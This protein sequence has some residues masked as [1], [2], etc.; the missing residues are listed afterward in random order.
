VGVL[1]PTPAVLA[2]GFEGQPFRRPNDIVVDRNG[3]VYFTDDGNPPEGQPRKPG[4]FY[5]T[6]AGRLVKLD[7]DIEFPNGVMLSPDEKVLY[8]ANSGKGEFIVAFDVGPD[9]L[10]S[11][12]R[13]FARLVARSGADGLAVDAAGRLYVASGGVQVFS[14]Q[15]QHLGT[16]PI[17]RSTQNVAFAGPDKKTLYVVGSGAVYK[18]A[19]LAEGFKGRAK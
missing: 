17:P 10:V 8:V 12:R 9:G 3:G 5:I 18:I 13:N 2:D 15:G 11:N 6:P 19:M 1:A 4:V 7:D 14:Q 16:I